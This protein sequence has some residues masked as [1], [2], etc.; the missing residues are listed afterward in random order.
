MFGKKFF[1]ANFI[2]VSLLIGIVIFHYYY[3]YINL[4]KDII[5]YVEKQADY[6]AQRIAIS[7]TN[8]YTSQKFIISNIENN[9]KSQA[10]FI[11]LLNSVEKFKKEE[12]TDFASESGLEIIAIIAKNYSIINSEKAITLKD[13]KTLVKS[14]NKKL[15]FLKN[16]NLILYSYHGVYSNADIIT[17]IISKEFFEK[18]EMFTLKGLINSILSQRQDIKT[19][20]IIDEN[21]KSPSIKLFKNKYFIVK[22]PFKVQKRKAILI[23]IDADYPLKIIHSFKHNLYVFIFV[24][25]LAGLIGNYFIYRLQRNFINQIREYERKIA[26]NE[27]FAAIGRSAG[28]IAHEIRNPLNAIGIGLQRILYETD[29]SDNSE[30]H[31]LIN[32][33]LNEL[34]RINQKVTTFLDYTKPIK[35]TKSKVNL[36][37]IIE[38]CLIF[39][40][41][42]S[43]KVEVDVPE[44]FIINVDKELFSQVISN[45]L[46][47]V[48]E[49]ENTKFL[50]IYVHNDNLI[51]EN[52]GIKQ[53]LDVE[54]IFEPYF[55]TKTNGSGLGLAIVKKI[56]DA[57]EGE[58]KA[59]VEDGIIR[60][61]IGL[62]A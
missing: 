23:E 24:M 19:I 30:Y 8:I 38:E 20:K 26:K 55:T 41:N 11:D 31:N 21:I 50:K 58:I 13:L 54:K 1:I 42:A 37:K 45:L 15:I 9:L 52:D 46:R 7:A 53:D 33:I 16:R 4:Q 40:K 34:K 28:I 39:Y 62:K 59:E 60:I 43:I 18:E 17:G 48:Y 47:N 14:T 56:I 12:L 6:I 36:R 44:N 51:F 35:L 10:K 5:N 29:I 22:V 2:F 61:I 27:K 57:H 32:T 25:I 3:H 49:N